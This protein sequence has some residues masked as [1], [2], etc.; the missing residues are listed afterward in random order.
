MDHLWAK[1]EKNHQ[2]AR[3]PGHYKNRISIFSLDKSII[4]TSV[5]D[6]FSAVCF[7][8]NFL[9]FH[10]LTDITRSIKYNFYDNSFFLLLHDV[11]C[12]A[13]TKRFDLLDCGFFWSIWQPEKL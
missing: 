2:P 7:Q 10:S 11:V 3:I 6:S 9:L 8:R 4:Q 13:L 5:S 1:L 12:D